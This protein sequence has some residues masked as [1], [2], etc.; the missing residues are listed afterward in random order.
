MSR[1]WVDLSSREK[2]NEHICSLA[3]NHQNAGNSQEASLHPE[4]IARDLGDDSVPHHRRAGKY[5]L[6]PALGH[7]AIGIE[8]PEALAEVSDL[9]V[10][11]GIRVK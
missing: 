10:L 8:K 1:S 11:L 2:D 3:M 4:P 5:D 9:Q 7:G 6:V